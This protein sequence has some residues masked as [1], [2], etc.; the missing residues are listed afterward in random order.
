MNKTMPAPLT[1]TIT[2]DA[3]DYIKVFSEQAGKP[4]SNLRVGI[5][6]GGCTLWIWWT[7]PPKTTR[8]SRTTASSCTLTATPTSSWLAQVW[9]IR[10]VSTARDSSST[11]PTPR[12]HAVAGHPSAFSPESTLKFDKMNRRTRLCGDSRSSRRHPRWSAQN[13]PTPDPFRQTSTIP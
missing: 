5:K 10:A 9:N 13:P 3:A 8:L 11:T 1:I 4:G 2:A 12:Q 6:G 7:N